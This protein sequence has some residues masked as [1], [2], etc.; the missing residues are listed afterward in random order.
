MSATPSDGDHKKKE[1]GLRIDTPP[2]GEPM[3]VGRSSTSSSIPVI[4]ASAKLGEEDSPTDSPTTRLLAKPFQGLSV[5]GLLLP[6][7]ALVSSAQK[8]DMLPP[9]PVLSSASQS[10]RKKTAE[11][12]LLTKKE[13]SKDSDEESSLMDA[14]FERNVAKVKALLKSNANVNEQTKGGETALQHAILGAEKADDQATIEIITLLLGAKAD[15]TLISDEQ[16][17]LE[18]AESYFSKGSIVDLLKKAAESSTDSR[19]STG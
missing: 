7:A 6:A 10:E 17:A 2:F 11:K 18:K 8:S 15:V 19:S 5:R 4:Q 13:S 14:A 1:E 9:A 3:F 12:L 16:T